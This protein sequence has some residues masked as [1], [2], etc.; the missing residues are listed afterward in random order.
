MAEEALSEGCKTGAPDSE[1]GSK[2]DADCDSDADLKSGDRDCCSHGVPNRDSDSGDSSSGSDSD[3]DNDPDSRGSDSSFDSDSD[4]GSDSDSDNDP[5]S[6]GSDSSFDSDSDSGSDSDSDS[7]SDSRGS[8]SGSSR[9][10][11]R[12]RQGQRR[13]RQRLRQLLRHRLRHRRL[14]YRLNQTAYHAA[15]QNRKGVLLG[16]SLAHPKQTCQCTR[17]RSVWLWPYRLVYILPCPRPACFVPPAPS[18][19][20]RD[21]A[22]AGRRRR[23]A[24]WGT[25]AGDAIRSRRPEE[26]SQGRIMTMMLG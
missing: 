5:D 21:D 1:T 16:D 2:G 15:I 24:G 7:G 22:S 9:Q 19:P 4:S 10:R 13:V 12:Q 23:A 3:S 6:R 20:P 8:D 14:R 18:L 26:G 17:A 25:G 11:L